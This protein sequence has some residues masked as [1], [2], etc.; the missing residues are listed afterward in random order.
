M[1]LSKR[2]VIRDVVGGKYLLHKKYYDSAGQVVARYYRVKNVLAR[3]DM[4]DLVQESNPHLDCPAA[5]RQVSRHIFPKEKQA[6]YIK[7]FVTPKS[8]T[9]DRSGIKLEK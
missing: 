5:S 7:G 3:R 4:I 2:R 6:G 9:T 8:T 1:E